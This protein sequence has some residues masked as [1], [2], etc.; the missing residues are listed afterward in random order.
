[1]TLPLHGAKGYHVEFDGLEGTVRQPVYLYETR[2]V[3]T[4]LAGRLRLAGTLELG[5]DP[6][7]VGRRRIAAVVAAGVRHIEGVAG[8]R[9]SHVWRGLRPMSSDGMPIIGCTPADDRVIVATGHGVLGITL[10]PSTAELVA[11][12]AGGKELEPWL[13]ALDPGRFRRLAGF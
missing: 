9:P 6:E 3:A 2:V 11:T 1:V 8:A 5:S 7:A 10:A 13:D 12:L 4:P